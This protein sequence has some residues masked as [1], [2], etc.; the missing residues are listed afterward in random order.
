MW[1][2]KPAL[3]S[4]PAMPDLCPPDGFKGDSLAIPNSS[5]TLAETPILAVDF[6]MTGLDHTIDPILSIGFVAVEAGEIQ[7]GTARHI[8]IQQDPGSNAAAVIHGLGHDDVASGIDHGAA[9]HQL[10]TA[11]SGR[12][13]LAHHAA[14][15]TAFLGKAL[16]DMGVASAR[17]P[18]I[19]TE[20]VE[21]HRLELQQNKSASVRLFD[22]RGRYGLPLYKAHNAL[23]DA[24]ATAELFIAQLA[25]GDKGPSSKIKGYATLATLV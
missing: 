15:E 23:T 19:C 4:L 17:W 2:F 13:L 24:L 10:L 14:I 16:M 1:P 18:A 11:L 7:L 22:T 5:Q 25:H 12:V 9:I 21:S 20:R 3:G 8:I 6:E